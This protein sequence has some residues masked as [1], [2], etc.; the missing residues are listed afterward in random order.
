MNV[1]AVSSV[2][3]VSVQQVVAS[4]AVAV[5]DTHFIC[6]FDFRES[7]RIVRKCDQHQHFLGW[8]CKLTLL[9][10]IH[11]LSHFNNSSSRIKIN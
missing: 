3:L 10:R 6:S 7:R 2:R 11:D 4:V 9:R 5:S 1:F 8:Q